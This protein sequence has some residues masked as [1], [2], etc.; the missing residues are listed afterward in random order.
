MNRIRLV[1]ALAL[2]LLV[3]GV[4]LIP[5]AIASAAGSVDTR[6]PR[7][8]SAK[9]LTPGPL[10][11]GAS[12]QVEWTVEEDRDLHEVSLYFASPVSELVQL[13]WTSGTGTATRNGNMWTG[14]SSAVVDGEVWV[15]GTY[16]P[17]SVGLHDANPDQG[18][19]T[20]FTDMPT[21]APG[22]FS[23]S[24]T[25]PDMTQPEL[26]SSKVLT[27]GPLTDGDTLK[28]QWTV[29]EDRNLTAVAI[30][31]TNS[32]GND[33]TARWDSSTGAPATRNGTQWSGIAT[34]TVDGD[35]WMTGDYV[36]Q[37]VGLLDDVH[38]RPDTY[39]SV[40]PAASPGNFTVGDLTE[41]KTDT[42]LAG[43]SRYTTAVA[44]SQQY[45]QVGK[46]VILATGQAYA[47]ALA[48]GPVAARLKGSLLL[49]PTGSMLPEVRAEI[50][51]LKPSEIIVVGSTSAVSDTV[52]AAAKAAAGG[53]QLTRIGGANRVETAAMLA[54]KYFPDAP[55]ALL[56]TGWNFPDALSA[57]TVGAVTG[58]PVL[59]TT[60]GSLQPE[61][62][63]WLAA[64]PWT[65]VSLVGSSSALNDT[66]LAEVQQTAYG[67]APVRYAGADRYETN[68]EL[69]RGFFDSSLVDTTIGA[70]GRNFPDALV[71]SV[72]AAAENA[73]LVLTPG[74]CVTTATN[75]YLTEIGTTN[76]ITVGSEA[77]VSNT[78]RSTPC[79]V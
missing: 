33:V 22:N 25:N 78:W 53:V 43:D 59:L 6:P 47:D 54:T 14:V 8:V 12:V 7:L 74:G 21:V 63:D 79:P 71:A 72:I 66:V 48:A 75:E 64:R 2:S 44:V 18:G 9:I 56:A 40:I 42:R 57:S 32:A 23:V 31:F 73:P 34:A 70:T 24:G 68:V 29:Q 26:V 52:A 36:P 17:Y 67:T 55:H 11:A 28:V 15:D 69:M 45:G 4:L 46:P 77:T 3:A 19:I 50:A 13:N 41:T 61:T 16:S 10:A 39:F 30:Y 51:R 60:T 37:S 38:V 62:R 49:T 58:S 20:Y 65:R 5:N 35:T 76:S 27:P 1:A